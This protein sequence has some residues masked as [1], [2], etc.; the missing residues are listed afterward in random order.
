MKISDFVDG[1]QILRK[2]YKSENA[3]CIGAEHDI[4]Y[5]YSTDTP[6]ESA[7]IQRLVELG[8][9]Q[10]DAEAGDDGEF[11]AVH[12]DQHESWAAYT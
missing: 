5:M 8:W 12:Y 6:V 1:I 2:Y 7:D 4:F 9:F 10:P 3:F 11:S